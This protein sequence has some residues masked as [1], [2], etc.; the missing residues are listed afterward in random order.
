MMENRGANHCTPEMGT[1]RG[2]ELPTGAQAEV[3]EAISWWEYV[4]GRVDMLLEADSVL[5]GEPETSVS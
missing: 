2:T 1:S 5:A 4:D 3:S